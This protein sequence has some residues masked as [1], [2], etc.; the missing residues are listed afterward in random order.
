MVCNAPTDR[1]AVLELLGPEFALMLAGLAL[2]RGL[3]W[4]EQGWVMLE[5][6]NYFLLFPCL[7]FLSI[8]KAPG[9]IASAASMMLAAGTSAACAIAMGMACRWIPQTDRKSTR[10]NSSHTDISR[11]PS[12]A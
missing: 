2:R 10:L 12:S 7:L 4:P 3:A 9:S 1:S 5:K 6:L 11:M 8:V